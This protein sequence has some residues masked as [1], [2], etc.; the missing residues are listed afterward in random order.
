[1]CY[2]LDTSLR[3]FARDKVHIVVHAILGLKGDPMMGRTVMS[4]KIRMVLYEQTQR[5]QH[6]EA[7]GC[8]VCT[9]SILNT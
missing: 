7:V 3:T 5:Q 2:S 6:I 4:K 9:A 1:M 8:D